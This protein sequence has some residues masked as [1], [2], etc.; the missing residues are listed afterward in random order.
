MLLLNN[1]TCHE[2]QPEWNFAMEG[3]NDFLAASSSVSSSGIKN[4]PAASHPGKAGLM[5]LIRIGERN[6][7]SA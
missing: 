3:N 7:E 2:P 5:P 6:D 1:L 4:V